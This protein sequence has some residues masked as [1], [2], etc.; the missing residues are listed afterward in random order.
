MVKQK[1]WWP[2]YSN[3]LIWAVVQKILYGGK[4]IVNRKGSR[5][6]GMWLPHFKWLKDGRT[7]GYYPSRK[8]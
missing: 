1:L 8:P 5:L 4:I 7:Y 3:C 2:K 6:Y